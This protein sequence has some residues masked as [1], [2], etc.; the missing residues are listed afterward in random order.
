M[1]GL[2]PAAQH[3]ARQILGPQG[4]QSLAS[5]GMAQVS[6]PRSKVVLTLAFESF[7]AGKQIPLNVEI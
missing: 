5:M 3:E 2:F 7:H 6:R 4:R 1:A